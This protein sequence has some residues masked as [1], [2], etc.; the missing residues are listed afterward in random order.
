MDAS[1]PLLNPFLVSLLAWFFAGHLK[2]SDLASTKE[3]GGLGRSVHAVSS[4]LAAKGSESSGFEI[5]SCLSRPD[6]SLA[7]IATPPALSGNSAFC[8]RCPGGLYTFSVPEL[9]PPKGDVLL[10]DGLVVDL[11]VN[12]EIFPLFA[13]LP[14][15]LK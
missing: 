10:P 9:A 13:L 1:S 5:E 15:D 2:S 14:V 11:D 7:V 6:G 8:I 4:N 12:V 3:S